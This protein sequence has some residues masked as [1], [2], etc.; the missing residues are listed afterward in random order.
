MLSSV[1]EVVVRALQ[2]VLV[3][4]EALPNVVVVIDIV[5]ESDDYVPTTLAIVE[6]RTAIISTRARALATERCPFR[7][8]VGDTSTTTRFAGGYWY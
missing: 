4:V 8:C 7:A 1:D 3:T 5:V 2:I 6:H